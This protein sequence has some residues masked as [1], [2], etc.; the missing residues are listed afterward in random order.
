MVIV[1]WRAWRGD[2]AARRRLAALIVLLLSFY[3]LTAISRYAVAPPSSSRYLTVGL[4]F[5]LL[6]LVEAFRGTRVRRWAVL[7]VMLIA[8]LAFTG[9]HLDGFEEG[10]SRFLGRTH[11]V[12]GALAALDLLGRQR[13]PSGLEFAPQAAPLLRAG[14]W[15]DARDR[16]GGDPGYTTAQLPGAPRAARRPCR[17]R[18]R[19]ATRRRPAREGDRHK[20]RPLSGHR[21]RRRTRPR[22]GRW[23]APGRTAEKRA[24]ASGAPLRRRLDPVAGAP[25][26]PRTFRPGARGG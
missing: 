12:R 2:P 3:A 19:T 17:G 11:Q 22:T 4:V 20:Q 14:P 5:M 26:R 13:V 23:T 18:R 16:L 15:L 8:L 24:R 6:L 10:R 25:R 7:P 21:R 9:D 1:A